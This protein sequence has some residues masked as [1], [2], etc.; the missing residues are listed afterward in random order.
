MN[1]GGNTIETSS[2]PYALQQAVKKNPL[3][4]WT[5]PDCAPCNDARMHLARR[6]LPYTERNAQKDAESLKKL[7]GSNEAPV[8]VVGTKPIKGYLASDWDAALDEAGYPRTLPPRFKPQVKIDASAKDDAKK[9]V[10]AKDLAS[11]EA[12]AKK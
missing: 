8:L 3:T 4:L 1:V 10:A 7:T 11:K 9:E 5:F 2:M 6:Q 12:A